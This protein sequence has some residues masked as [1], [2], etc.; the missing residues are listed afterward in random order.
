MRLYRKGKTSIRI[1]N[2]IN[3]IMLLYFGKKS[4]FKISIR[5]LRVYPIAYKENTAMKQQ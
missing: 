4:V 3:S 1:F 2:G 5:R